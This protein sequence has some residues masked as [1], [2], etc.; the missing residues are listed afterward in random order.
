[1][2]S[3]SISIHAGGYEPVAKV[4]NQA[5]ETKLRLRIQKWCHPRF[6]FGYFKVWILRA[7]VMGKL[8]RRFLRT[9]FLGK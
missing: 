9:L 2:T 1:M 3:S 5:A 8:N 6:P 7:K 4:K